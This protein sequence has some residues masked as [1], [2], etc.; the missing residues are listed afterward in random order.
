MEIK[1]EPAARALVT[2]ETLIAEAEEIRQR[3][4]ESKHLARLTSY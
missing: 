2:A 4:M 3:A 1:G